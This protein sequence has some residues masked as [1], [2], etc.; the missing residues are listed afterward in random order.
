LGTLCGFIAT[1]NLAGDDRRTQLLCVC[2]QPRCW[3]RTVR[4]AFA[5]QVLAIGV[6]PL[7]FVGAVAAFAGISV[8][9]QLTFWTVEAG[10]SQLLGPLLVAVVAT[11][12]HPFR[13]GTVCHL[14]RG[15]AADL[16][17]TMNETANLPEPLPGDDRGPSRK[18]RFKF[19]RVNEITGTFVLVV[20]AVLIAAVVW[21]GRSQRWFRSNVTLRIVLPEAGAAGIRQGSEVYFH[22]HRFGGRGAKA[23]GAGQRSDE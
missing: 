4:K 23:P 5:R 14:R 15:I 18:Q 22:R 11:G 7:W 19:R 9:V 20:V 16:P 21:T 1:G 3:V 6:E 17:V 13:R 8:V 10:Q 2:V 12:A